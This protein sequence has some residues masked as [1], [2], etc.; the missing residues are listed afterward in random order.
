MRTLFRWGLLCPNV[1]TAD[2][3]VKTIRQT[4]VLEDRLA[5][6][7]TDTGTWRQKDRQTDIGTWRQTDRHR[8]LKTDRLTRLVHSHQLSVHFVFS[9]QAHN[10]T[11][12]HSHFLHSISIRNSLSASEHQWK[13]K[14]GKAM[15]VNDW[16][17]VNLWNWI[18]SFLNN[19]FH[20]SSILSILLFFSDSIHQYNICVM[21][22]RTVF[23]D[24]SVVS[25]LDQNH[26][27][28]SIL[29]TVALKPAILRSE[30]V[31]G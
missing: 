28:L 1:F 20:L 13:Q 26:H 18:M 15:K 30:K 17:D 11:F 9:C 3:R 2:Q 16:S 24:N 29:S 21:L 8:Y 6:W 23:L 7:Q 14:Q 4:Q 27:K 31:F 10:F 12:V 22:S 25:E 5:D 19:L